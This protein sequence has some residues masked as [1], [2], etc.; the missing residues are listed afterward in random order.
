M[1]VTLCTFNVN[2]LCVRYRFAETFPGDASKKSAVSDPAEGYLPMY[3]Q[4][5]FQL[6]TTTSASSPPRPSPGAGRAT[7]TSS[8]SK[9][10]RA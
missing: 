7:P 4:A 10:S 3:N 6:S 1:A 9:R 2:N 5:A 8:A